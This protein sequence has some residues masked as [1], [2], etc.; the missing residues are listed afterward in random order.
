MIA[1][2]GVSTGD[3]M[4]ATSLD[5]TLRLAGGIWVAGRLGVEASVQAA[6]VI[7][8]PGYDATPSGGRTP[9]YYRFHG[10]SAAVVMRLGNPSQVPAR[11]E[12]GLGGY[13]VKGEELQGQ[14]TPAVTALGMHLGVLGYLTLSRRFAL[15]AGVRPTWMPTVNGE[16]LWF[17]PI[18]IG[19]QLR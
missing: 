15:S 7:G 12:F 5:Y 19:G 8:N 9:V 2:L 3:T 18:E 6:K 17:F 14:V 11:I 13:R 16:S 4:Y 10:G 1:G